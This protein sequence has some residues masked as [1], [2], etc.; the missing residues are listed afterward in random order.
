MLNKPYEDLDIE[1]H[2][3]PNVKRRYSVTSDIVAFRRCPRQ[4][5]AFRVHDYAP[6][7]QTQLY[8]GTVVHQVL[9]RCHAHYHGLQDPETKGSIPDDGAILSDDEIE[10]YFNEVR[11]AAE[12]DDPTPPAPTE[13]MEYFIE[14]ENGLKS[15]GIYAITPDLR[16]KAI[17][18]LQYFNAL[19]GERLY[20]RV[21]DTEHRLQADRR[22]HILHGVVD[23]LVRES[24]DT[25]DPAE[26][27]IWDYKG[28]SRLRLTE[29]DLRTYNFQM[30]VYAGL[31]QRKHGVPPREA[32]LYF[33]NELDGPMPP[34][35]RPVNALLSISIE[36]D[37]VE[38]AMEA[39]TESVG[40]IE[41]ARERDE[42]KP[43]RPGEIS[44]QD[45]AIC[46]LRWD[47]PTPNEGEGVS[48]RHP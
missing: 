11:T 26:G 16:L 31:Y 46:D 24:E 36:P 19:E 32:I 18:V 10:A 4:Y 44:D 45:C 41:E 2:E 48:L 42:W 43:A 7:H 22:D 37:E 27:E 47:C 25:T 23:L 35:D 40:E 29:E 39:F 38:E 15:R 20:P 34:G 9:D 12:E 33:V 21:V 14:V 5:G 28:T 8:Y 6:A 17:R 13:L 1:P 30:R 3:E